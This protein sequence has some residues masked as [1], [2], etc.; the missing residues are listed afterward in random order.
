MKT[1]LKTYKSHLLIAIA[2]GGILVGCN[3]DLPKAT[4]IAPPTP[5]STVSIAQ[6]VTTSPN[7]TFLAAAIT[8]ADSGVAAG[9]RLADLLNNPNSTYTVFAPDDDAM[10]L[11]LPAL[12]LPPVIGAFNFIPVAQMRSILQY[13]IVGGERLTADRIPTTFPNLYLQ[14]SL[15][16]AAS[17]PISPR[18]SMFPSRRATG[19]WV[20]TIPIKATD[21]QFSNGV[22]HTVAAVLLPPSQVIAQITAPNPDLTYFM[23]AIAR[24]DSGIAV[25]SRF[26]DAISNGLANL[27]VFAPNNAAFQALLTGAIYQ[28]LV[29]QGV[30]PATALAQAQALASTPAVFSNPALFPVLTA[31]TVRGIIAYHLLGVRAFSVNI[32]A[33]T[34]PVNTLLSLPG[35]TTALTVAATNTSGAVTVKGNANATASK[36]TI[37][38]THAVNGVIHIIDQV[39]LPF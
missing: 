7:F 8:R 38:N 23:A 18:M 6:A 21:A 17:V 28:A 4:A 9:S 30:P 24:A 22:V 31:Q 11:S 26:I 27:T 15:I 32:P 10:K 5:P 13:H 16:L 29:G 25:N 39:M 2:C 19:A 14:S 33:T 34:T 37:A 12:G 35:T 3:K 36:V 20:N 1:F